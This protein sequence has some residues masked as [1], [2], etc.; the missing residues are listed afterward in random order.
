M[1]ELVA[2][3]TSMAAPKGRTNTFGGYKY[4]NCEDILA[5]VKPLL[6]AQECCLTVSDDIRVLADRVYVVA[7]ATIKNGAGEIAECTGY[8]R[9]QSAKKGMDEAQITGAASSYARKYA[10]GGLFLLDDSDEAADMRPATEEPKGN[11]KGAKQE[12]KL[13]PEEE[14]SLRDLLSQSTSYTEKVFCDQAKIG[15]LSDLSRAR[16]R[17]AFNHAQTV[18]SREVAQ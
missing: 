10:L 17:G 15:K 14:A 12:D 18:I 4:R 2:I 11:G 3:Q 16:F 8:A 6:K 5:A 13:T 9:E 7:T 1:K